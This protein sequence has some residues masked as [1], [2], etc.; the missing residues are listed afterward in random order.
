MHIVLMVWIQRHFTRHLFY[1]IFKENVVVLGV[2]KKKKTVLFYARFL[3]FYLSINSFYSLITL[4]SLSLLLSPLASC[5]SPLSSCRLARLASTANSHH[6]KP[7]V[8][9]TP[10]SLLPLSL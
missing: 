3:D 2:V 5:Q 6:G 10:S 1:F 9:V 8:G 4:R 7:P